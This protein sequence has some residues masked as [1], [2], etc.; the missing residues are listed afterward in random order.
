MAGGSATA[1]AANDATGLAVAMQSF[2]DDEYDG[3]QNTINIMLL[4]ET[5]LVE[6]P[7][8]NSGGSNTLAEADFGT[9]AFHVEADG[10]VDLD[11]TAAAAAFIPLFRGPGTDTGDASG[12]LIGVFQDAASYG[13]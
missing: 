10:D 11:S 1:L 9:V 5:Q 13:S 3:T 4:G 2:S 8:V 6:V 7:F 12:T